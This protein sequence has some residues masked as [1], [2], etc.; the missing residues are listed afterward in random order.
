MFNQAD[1]AARIHVVRVERRLLR[2]HVLEGAD[3]QAGRYFWPTS[4]IDFEASQITIV[5]S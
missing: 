5:E 2:A 4:L 1:V 3:S